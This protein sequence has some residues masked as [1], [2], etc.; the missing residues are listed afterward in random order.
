MIMQTNNKIL[1]SVIVFLAILNLSTIITIVYHLNS[2]ENS[3]NIVLDK[4]VNI[5][6]KRLGRF[7]KEQLN[8]TPQQHVQFRTFRQNF[9]HNANGITNRLQ[10]KRNEFMIELEKDTSETETLNS[11][12]AEIGNLHTELKHITFAYYIQMK[13]ICTKEQ[14]KKLHDIFWSMMNCDDENEIPSSLRKETNGK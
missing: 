12:A 5:P 13:D 6:D 11:M 8:L 3:K 7:F 14:Q 9:H 10:L 2:P 4:Q 1:I